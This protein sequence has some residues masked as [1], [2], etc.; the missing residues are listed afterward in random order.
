VLVATATTAARQ[1]VGTF[2][3]DSDYSLGAADSTKVNVYVM[4]DPA[5]QPLAVQ[6]ADSPLGPSAGHPS[7][8][9]RSHMNIGMQ[10]QME[11]RGKPRRRSR[12]GQRVGHP[13]PTGNVVTG[14]DLGLTM[15]GGGEDI[16]THS[17]KSQSIIRRNGLVLEHVMRQ[18]G[19]QLAENQV[20]A[21]L[22]RE[23]RNI[24]KREGTYS[25][26][27]AT[28]MPGQ[29]S[30][31]KQVDNKYLLVQVRRSALGGE[32]EVTGQQQSNDGRR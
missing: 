16:T 28:R 18:R 23:L 10:S 19:Q 26:K 31:A 20:L 9:K 29:Q 32:P 8:A 27:G 12:A 11:R 24:E 30:E 15:V 2:G 7:Q 3:N 6:A 1:T 22:H 21:D 17:L 5:D 4:H 25:Y 13:E 14:G